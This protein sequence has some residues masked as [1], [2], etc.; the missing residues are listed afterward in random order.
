M[1]AMRVAK[2]IDR[3]LEVVADWRCW[4]PQRGD[5]RSQLDWHDARYVRPRHAGTTWAS[6]R[7]SGGDPRRL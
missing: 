1:C 6:D 5:A 4:A 3:S 7:G 2:T